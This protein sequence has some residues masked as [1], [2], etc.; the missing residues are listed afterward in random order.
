VICDQASVTFCLHEDGFVSIQVIMDP[1]M[2]KSLGVISKMC[3]LPM[4]SSAAKVMEGPI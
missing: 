2:C 1:P 4:N 3:M